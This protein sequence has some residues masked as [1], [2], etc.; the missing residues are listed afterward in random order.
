MKLARQLGADTGNALK[1][2]AAVAA[3]FELV[4]QREPSRAQQIRHQPPDQVIDSK[5]MDSFDA[6]LGNDLSDRPGTRA[7]GGCG[8][9][10]ELNPVIGAALGI[11]QL[12]DAR[13]RCSDARVI[14]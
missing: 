5:L 7:N 13:G 3:T 11:E 6:L 1:D 4:E 8:P 9:S 14:G 10:P 12:G 2:I